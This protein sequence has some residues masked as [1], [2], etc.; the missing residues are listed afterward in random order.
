MEETKT[1]LKRKNISEISTWDSIETTVKD[2]GFDRVTMLEATPKNMHRLMLKIN[3]L[4]EVVN[5]LK[6]KQNG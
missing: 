1:E 3:E 4:I 2:M 5:E 6:N